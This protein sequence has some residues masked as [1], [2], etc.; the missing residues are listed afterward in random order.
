MSQH[1]KII[2]GIVAAGT[3]ASIL[4]VWLVL[5]NNPNASPTDTTS[6]SSLFGISNSRTSTT[7]I[8]PED[9]NIVEPIVSD[10][11]GTQKIFKIHDGPVAG[12]TLIHTTNPTST[13]VRYVLANNGH[14]VELPLGTT[15]GKLPK[16]I[17]NTT[18]PGIEQVAWGK[19]GRGA[20]LQ[21]T[22]V[23]ALKSLH[24]AL[25]DPT[26][27]SSA[28]VR[29]QF[30]PVGISALSVSPD[31][32]SVAYLLQ[33]NAGVDG[34]VAA[35]N[36]ADPKKL[37]SLPLSHILLSWPSPATI[38]AQSPA[39]YGVPGVVFSIDTKT[40]AVA[41]LLY[42]AGISA[43]ANLSFSRVVY[44]VPSEETRITYVRNTTTG[45]SKPLSFDPLP[46]QCIWG[47]TKSE[48]LYCAAPTDYTPPNYADLLHLGYSLN[49]SGIYYFDTNSGKTSVVAT[50]G[51]AEGG[52]A[53]DMVEMA[54][55]S[56]DT[57]LVY[58]RRGDRSLWGVRL[59]Q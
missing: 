26:A 34:Y 48:T 17:S 42:A 13:I 21:F 9:T 12:A 2:G 59:N 32:A 44:Q 4:I 49:Q 35:I 31:G 16:T 3:V 41:P 38:M 33:T 11:L 18:I 7:E 28:P 23:G 20:I 39:A 45:L 29:I 25:P 50:P 10:E 51:G 22:D 24:M 40:G 55:S 57:Y 37:F 27:T 14:V 15:G 56:D 43:T 46:E 19:Q 5:L 1:Y 58:I 52:I 47:S 30:L 36:G 6:V 53:G 54:I 8:T